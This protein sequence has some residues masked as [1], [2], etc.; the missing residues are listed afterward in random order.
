MRIFSGIKEWTLEERCLKLI[1][2]N[3]T[4]LK[5]FL[6][7]NKDRII[8][9]IICV[10]FGFFLQNIRH[11]VFHQRKQ[12]KPDVT[13]NNLIVPYSVDKTALY[14]GVTNNGDS[15]ATNV[16]IYI[17]FRHQIAESWINPLIPWDHHAFDPQGSSL[18]ENEDIFKGTNKAGIILPSLPPKASFVV[19]FLFQCSSKNLAESDLIKS[20]KI[21]SD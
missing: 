1:K 10:A 15:E 12:G 7:R 9:G 11:I 16:G 13:Y 6:F 4:F 5:S 17:K 14:L 3:S 21:V 20:V 18:I 8:V 19:G 2:M